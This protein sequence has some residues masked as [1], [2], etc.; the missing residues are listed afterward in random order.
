[1]VDFDALI[2]KHLHREEKE[3][4]IGEYYPSEL[5]SC[6][7]QIYYRYT[8]PLPVSPEK[9]RIFAA[10]EI[11]HEFIAK[12]LAAQTDQHLTERSITIPIDFK[13]QISLRGRLDNF[14][15]L[16]DGEPTVVEVKSTASLAYV[17][18]AKPEHVMQL[19]PYLL[20]MNCSKGHVLYVEKNTLQVKSFEVAYDPKTMQEISDRVFSLHFQ[21]LLKTPPTPDWKTDKSKAWMCGYCEHSAHCSQKCEGNGR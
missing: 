5:G 10:G 11:I 16:N 18:S 17:N 6:L 13:N 2:D 14:F 19:T 3:R 7:L 20:A 1:M 21:I 8:E 12:V 15:V 9:R 4:K